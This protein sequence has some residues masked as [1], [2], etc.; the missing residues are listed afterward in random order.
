MGFLWR[1]NKMF[2]MWTNLPQ[3]C[4][5]KS[6]PRQTAYRLRN[7]I[8]YPGQKIVATAP[9]HWGT[10]V[11]TQWRNGFI[12]DWTS[13]RIS[14]P[15]PSHGRS[16]IGKWQTSQGMA[17]WCVPCGDDMKLNIRFRSS[18]TYP[19]IHP[20]SFCFS[21]WRKIEVFRFKEAS[22]EDLFFLDL[23]LFSS[24]ANLLQAS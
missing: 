1:M 8:S 7:G 14:G 23:S 22:I 20:F 6:K 21:I 11:G 15:V 12:W 18:P 10:R 19:P 9:R 3:V 24:D 4:P 13:S 17:K 5:Y 16:T 2:V